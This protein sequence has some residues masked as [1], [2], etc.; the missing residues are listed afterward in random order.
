M[1]VDIQ[2]S[3]S[4]VI[5]VASNRSA[6]IGVSTPAVAVT[7]GITQA[8]NGRLEELEQSNK[9]A[10]DGIT[11]AFNGRLEELE[12]KQ[13]SEETD[14]AVDGIPQSFNERL[15]ELEQASKDTDDALDGKVNGMDFLT[16][17]RLIRDN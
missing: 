14:D 10:L 15:E 17:Y 13:A 6:V 12:L 1:A 8:F 5:E 11:R 9:D 2:T 16:H 7:D 3:K 4:R